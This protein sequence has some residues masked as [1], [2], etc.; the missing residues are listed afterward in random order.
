MEKFAATDILLLK[1]SPWT[2]SM[3]GEDRTAHRDSLLSKSGA[4]ERGSDGLVV[5]E[6]IIDNG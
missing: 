4:F 5:T 1:C 3:S 6:E 2:P